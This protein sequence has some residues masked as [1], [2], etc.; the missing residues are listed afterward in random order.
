M[1]SRRPLR[2]VITSGDH[3]GI[4][5]EVIGKALAKFRPQHPVHIFLL[6]SV[7]FPHTH[8]RKIDQAFQRTPYSALS[9]ALQEAD[10]TINFADIILPYRP[11]HWVTLA[12]QHTLRKD[13]A[14]MVTGPLSKL[15]IQS[16]GMRAIG[17][18]E[19]LQKISKAPEPFMTFLGPKFNVL[20]ATGHCPLRQVPRAL[21][22]ERLWQAVLA[23]HALRPQ[24]KLSHSRPLAL[25]GLNP[26]AGE[27]GVIGH[28]EQRIF[29]AVLRRA[30]RA[31][32]PI[33]GPLVPDAAFLPAQ[34]S[35]YAI[36]ICA[37]HDQGLI[38]FKMAHNHAPCVHLTA[39]LPFIRTSVDHGTAKDLVGKNKANASSML[40]AIEWALHLAYHNRRRKV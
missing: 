11:A 22:A 26:H 29:S 33:S 30:Q 20:L 2:I 10:S 24:V 36:Y 40:A 5:P 9:S 1:P 34:W 16:E 14:A 37:Y 7:D 39:G 3:D 17:H 18:T 38:P 27:A 15:T 35:K 28:E 19:I 4:G 31:G 6:R 13:F 25:V 8:L 32:I 23:A 12:A 21:S